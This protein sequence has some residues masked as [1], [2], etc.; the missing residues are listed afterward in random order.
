MPFDVLDAL[1]RG[2]ALH[3]GRVNTQLAQRAQDVSE[4]E[5]AFRRENLTESIRQFAQQQQLERDKIAAQNQRTDATLDTQQRGQNIDIME[6]VG[7]GLIDMPNAQP[8]DFGFGAATPST[9]QQQVQLQMDAVRNSPEW[10]TYTPEQQGQIAAQV[11]GGAYL[12]PQATPSIDQVVF[13]SLLQSSD[14]DPVKA[15]ETF[16]KMKKAGQG[17]EKGLTANQA[18]AVEQAGVL[19]SAYTYFPEV[20]QNGVINPSALIQVLSRMDKGDPEAQSKLDQISSETGKSPEQVRSALQ[21]ALG[22]VNTGFRMPSDLQI[23]MPGYTGFGG[24]PQGAT[25][26]P[27]APP[28]AQGGL[29][30]SGPGALDFLRPRQ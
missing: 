2:A 5:L 15:Y 3:Q 22:Q 16:N 6:A 11:M 20:I 18:Y 27:E 25:P 24:A 13:E 17:G 12:Q 21:R 19:G 28:P 14:G 8:V 9:P 23:L 4:G 29:P 26:S 7:R 1:T 10:E 30:Q